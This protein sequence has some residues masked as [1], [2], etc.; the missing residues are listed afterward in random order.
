MTDATLDKKDALIQAAEKLFEYYGYQKTSISDITKEASLGKGT[1]YYYFNSKEDILLEIVRSQSDYIHQKITET[2]EAGKNTKE[3]IY[4]LLVK[5]F[6]YINEK[7]KLYMTLLAEEPNFFMTKVREFKESNIE[8]TRMK[9]TDIFKKGVEEG[10]I[11]N[12]VDIERVSDL[13]LRWFLLGDENL[14]FTITKAMYVS[15][16]EDMRTIADLILNGILVRGCK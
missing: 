7:G 10:D 9:I 3:R 15:F 6:T 11:R 4:A 12:D 16:Q 8:K 5:P 1:F 14:H 13:I 2:I